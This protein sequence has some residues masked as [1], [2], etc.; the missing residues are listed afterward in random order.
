VVW[1]FCYRRQC[2][3]IADALRSRM[4]APSR[5]STIVLDIGCGPTIPYDR[6]AAAF[7]VGVD[8][9]L[10]ALASNSDVDLALHT[11]AIGLPIG[12]G[13][14]DVVLALYAMH[15]MVGNSVAE[16]W[17]NVEAAFGEM[18]RVAKPG[19]VILL[20]E[21]CPWRAVWPA[22]RVVWKPVRRV[23]GEKIDFV[24]WPEKKLALQGAAAFRGATFTSE[25]F[26]ISPFAIFPPVIA[27]PK[28]KIPRAAYPFTACLLSWTLPT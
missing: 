22:E 9:S 6:P 7:V 2:T 25:H 20:L 26:T 28:L 11:S 23:L 13:T 24:F 16:S 15:H 3:Q 12:S 14:V 21:I 5:A 27:V 18:A 17:S 10:P 19:A 1:D 4:A 8:P